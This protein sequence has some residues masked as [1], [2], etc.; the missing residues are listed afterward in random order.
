[1][2][3]K[4]L[5]SIGL[6]ATACLS[7]LPTQGYASLFSHSHNGH[8]LVQDIEPNGARIEFEEDQDEVYEAVQEGLIKPFSELFAKVEQDL[9]GRVIKVELEEDDDL[10]VYELKLLYEQN[11][12]NVDYNATTLEMMAIKGHNLQQALKK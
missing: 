3:K 8:E 4:S 9:N 11:V 1:M 5:Y 7:A 6:L 2:S 10:W 12:I